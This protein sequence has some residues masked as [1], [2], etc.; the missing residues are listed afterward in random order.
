MKISIIDDAK[1]VVPDEAVTV[2]FSEYA[3][4]CLFKDFQARI[5][6]R[7]FWEKHKRKYKNLQT[8]QRLSNND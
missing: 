3:W 8:K 6:A 1:I 7:K 4:K 2:D 5:D